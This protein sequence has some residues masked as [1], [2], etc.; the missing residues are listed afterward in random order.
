MRRPHGPDDHGTSEALAG[1]GLYMIGAPR[2]ELPAAVLLALWVAH[3][4]WRRW[5]LGDVAAAF[6][7]DVE[8]VEWAMLAPYPPALDPYT[9]AVSVEYVRAS[10]WCVELWREG[11]S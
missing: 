3:C 5:Q 1:W 2:V 8:L 4:S 9:V 11:R 10:G 7:V 6:D